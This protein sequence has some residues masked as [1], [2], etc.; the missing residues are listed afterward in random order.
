MLRRQTTPTRPRT[1]QLPLEVG[2]LYRESVAQ[3]DQLE[4]GTWNDIPQM[5]LEMLLRIKVL[6]VNEVDGVGVHA[7]AVSEGG[8]N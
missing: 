2:C 5:T 7:A 3:E 4:R 6:L 8:A 1:Y